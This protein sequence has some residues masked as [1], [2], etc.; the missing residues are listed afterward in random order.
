MCGAH[1]LPYT[2]L[3]TPAPMSQNTNNLQ[4]AN[5]S[6]LALGVARGQELPARA[7]RR[8]GVSV[9]HDAQRGTPGSI[10]LHTHRESTP[11]PT[12]ARWR[13]QKRCR[14]PRRWRQTRHGTQPL[15][16]AAGRRAGRRGSPRHMLGSDQRRRERSDHG[17]RR[18]H[19][20]S[21]PQQWV[22]VASACFLTAGT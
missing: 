10:S 7:A 17:A 21:A 20:A 16:R 1:R 19:C 5:K 15:R 4:R 11:T 2:R 9:Q 12:D 3:P 13:Q 22:I 8:K 18:Q 14:P 6:V